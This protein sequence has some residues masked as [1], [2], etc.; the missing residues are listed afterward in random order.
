MSRR[1]SSLRHFQRTEPFPAQH[2][3]ERS[4]SSGPRRIHRV[5]LNI[6]LHNGSLEWQGRLAQ[7]VPSGL[8][9]LLG[10]PCYSAGIHFPL[11]FSP[12]GRAGCPRFLLAMVYLK[13][14]PILFIGSSP[15]T[16]PKHTSSAPL[17]PSMR[18]TF[19]E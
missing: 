6:D 16:Q 19:A 7:P 18:V 14:I 15:D 8:C 13:T 4:I 10:C 2:L 3:I 17:Q 12:D 5:G 1:R 9:R 11:I